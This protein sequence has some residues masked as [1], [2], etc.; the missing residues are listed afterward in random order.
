MKEHKDAVN[1]SLW[2]GSKQC[3]LT[4]GRDP[5][6]KIWSLADYSLSDKISTNNE[7]KMG[8]Q[9]IYL[10]SLNLIGVG[11]FTGKINLYNL[12]DKQLVKS[13][14]TG[15][16]K[17]YINSLLYLARIQKVVA[18]INENTIRVW[19][20]KECFQEFF[21]LKSDGSANFLITDFEEKYLM[22]TSDKQYIE[23]WRLTNSQM[24]EKINL[25]STIKNS[26]GILLFKNLQKALVSS[27]KNNILTIFQIQSNI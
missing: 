16:D 22:V 26:N 1:T 3:L 23:K 12:E 25:P 5:D 7:G 13:I 17:Y 8:C 15:S 19:D 24:K 20:A 6:I 14:S 21:D 11:F 27:W 10:D 2:I 9:M 18:Q 4:C